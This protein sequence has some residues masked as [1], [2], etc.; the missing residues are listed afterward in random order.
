MAYQLRLEFRDG[1]AAGGRVDL[2]SLDGGICE[3]LGVPVHPADWCCNW[4]DTVG[5]CL[6]LGKS[7]DEV[8]ATFH[9]DANLVRVVDYLESKFINASHYTR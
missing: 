1:P 9:D 2:V 3:A 6:A 4:M 5:L 8:R 7:W